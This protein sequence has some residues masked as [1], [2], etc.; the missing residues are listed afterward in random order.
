[1]EDTLQIDWKATAIEAA[2]TFTITTLAI[3]A[4]LVIYAKIK[5]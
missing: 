5:P 1:M 3:L 2:I 4:A